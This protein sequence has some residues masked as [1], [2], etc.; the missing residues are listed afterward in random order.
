VQELGHFDPGKPRGDALEELVSEMLGEIPGVRVAEANVRSSN[1][2]EEIDRLATNRRLDDG[3]VFFP[4]DL[5][6]ECKSQDGPVDATAVDRFGIKLEGRHLEVGLLVTAAG[7]TGR[8]TETAGT[9]RVTH[10]AEQNRWILVLWTAEL[11]RLR[12]AAHLVNLLELKR[13]RMR[14]G[15]H[16][17]EIGAQEMRTLDPDRTAGVIT[18]RTGWEGIQRAIMEARRAALQ[19]MLDRLPPEDPEVADGLANA[20]RALDT[21]DA[22]AQRHVDDSSY[23]PLWLQVRR[24]V[25]DFGA[26]VASLRLPVPRSGEQQRIVRREVERQALGSLRSW[27][28]GELWNY[29]SDYLLR[30]V[31]AHPDYASSESIAQILSLC[32]DNL[33]SI[34]EIDPADVYDEGPEVFEGE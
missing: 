2:D 10:W 23:D 5:L 32:V 19:E 11:S 33:V 28:G 16:V 31:E 20:R 24:L 25:V 6:V 22:E 17:R 7:V 4:N 29:L 1:Q 9:A 3:L 30:Q 34:D 18:F 21:V 26:A 12:S 27:V 14:A 15:F 13:T 8:E